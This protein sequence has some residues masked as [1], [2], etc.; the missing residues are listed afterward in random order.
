MPKFITL[1]RYSKQGLEKIKE[2][3]NRLDAFKML[4]ESMGAKVDAFYLTTGRYDMIVIV[5]APNTETIAK[6]ALTTASKGALTT[7]TLQAFPEQDY[8]KII[9]ELP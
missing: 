8:R 4:C 7:E 9:K 6:I 1:A 5:D 3:P 2:S